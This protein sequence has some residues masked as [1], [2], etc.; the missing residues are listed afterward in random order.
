MSAPTYHKHTNGPIP[1]SQMRP[2]LCIREP[3]E[4]TGG[5]ALL[6]N[7]GSAVYRVLMRQSTNAHGGCRPTRACSGTP[8]PYPVAVGVPAVPTCGMAHGW[9]QLTAFGAQDRWHFSAL[10]CGAPRRQLKR[11]PLAGWSNR[12]RLRTKSLRRGAR[13]IASIRRCRPTLSPY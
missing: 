4:A 8:T 12:G 2:I 3:P 9:L 13:G 7:S 11:K 1:I 10:L 5:G 6:H